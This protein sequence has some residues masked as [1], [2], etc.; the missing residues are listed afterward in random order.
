MSNEKVWNNTHKLGAKLYKA[1]ALITLF[2]LAFPIIAIW[3]V[4]VPVI[5]SAFF[6]FIYS[7]FDY[8]K[9]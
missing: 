4:L 8:Q 5:F 2:G 7:Y 1:S 3:F 6:L 9:N